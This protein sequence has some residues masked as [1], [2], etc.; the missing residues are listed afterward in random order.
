MHKTNCMQSIEHFST[1]EYLVAYVLN[2]E[3]TYQDRIF[4]KNSFLYNCQMCAL[5][6]NKIV[7]IVN[8]ISCITLHV[9]CADLEIFVW[10]GPGPTD[11]IL[12]TFLLSSH[13]L[14]IQRQSNSF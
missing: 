11:K 7:L 6:R 8:V 10:A 9:S 4:E 1:W 14:R 12:T 5:F 2:T 3:R 13:Q